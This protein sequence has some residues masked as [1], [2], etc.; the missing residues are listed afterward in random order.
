MYSYKKVD[1]N[2][3]FNFLDNYSTATV[4]GVTGY[5]TQ[6]VIDIYICSCFV[7]AIG[8]WYYCI[9]LVSW[10]DIAA[11]WSDMAASW[12]IRSSSVI[13]RSCCAS[14]SHSVSA[15]SSILVGSSGDALSSI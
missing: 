15:V 13:L 11:S 8:R 5:V 7:L 1:F 2:R 14:D 10:S 12:A 9:G 6:K 3:I 4:R